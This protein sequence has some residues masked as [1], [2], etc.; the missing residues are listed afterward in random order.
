MLTKFEVS[1]Y[2]SK[3]RIDLRVDCLL[4]EADLTVVYQ[5][6][7]VP[8]PNIELHYADVDTPSKAEAWLY[9]RIDGVAQTLNQK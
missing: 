4:K 6:L 1:V 3:T 9:S 2:I 7:V 5:D 8:N